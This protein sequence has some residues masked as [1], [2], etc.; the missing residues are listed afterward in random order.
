VLSVVLT[1]DISL[2]SPALK[3]RS[4][5][6]QHCPCSR[7][8]PYASHSPTPSPSPLLHLPYQRALPPS[9]LPSHRPR[10]AHSLLLSLPLRLPL[11]LPILPRRPIPQPRRTRCFESGLGASSSSL[12]LHF[13]PVINLTPP[14]KSLPSRRRTYGPDEVILEAM[15]RLVMMETLDAAASKTYEVESMGYLLVLASFVAD[16]Y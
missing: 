16:L 9:H 15:L 2:S 5:C 3:A 11:R 14:R 13:S 7:Y 4:P 10:L 12:S 6:S 8:C 1:S